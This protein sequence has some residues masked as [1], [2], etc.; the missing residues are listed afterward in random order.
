MNSLEIAT[1]LTQ[2]I[3][4]VNSSMYLV[5]NSQKYRELVAQAISEGRDL[6]SNELEMLRQDAQTAVDKL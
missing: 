1:L 5:E 4:L 2:I 6:T 3:S